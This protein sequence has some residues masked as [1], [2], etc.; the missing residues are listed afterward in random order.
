VAV[1]PVLVLRSMLVMCKCQLNHALLYFRPI[2]L[3]NA[4]VLD[5]SG[6]VPQ[7]AQIAGDDLLQY[8][9]AQIAFEESG[10]LGVTSAC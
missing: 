8:P 5:L 9:S 2:P 1:R 6:R 3:V 10:T 4:Q 7:I